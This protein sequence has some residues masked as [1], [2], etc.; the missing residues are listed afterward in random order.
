M[1]V[2][3]EKYELKY[4]A[5]A[6]K[7]FWRRVVFRELPGRGILK[8]YARFREP[9]YTRPAR[10]AHKVEGGLMSTRYLGDACIAVE[11]D[12]GWIK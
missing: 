2:V 11:C 1:S 5:P 4:P 6:V 8:N 9:F 7:A 12:S 3:L 10:S